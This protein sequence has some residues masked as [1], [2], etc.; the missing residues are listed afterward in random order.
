MLGKIHLFFGIAIVVLFAYTGHY[1]S[2]NFQYT[3]GK[4][5]MGRALTRAGHLYIL[6]FGLINAALGAHLKLSKNKLIR[7][8]QKFGSIIIFGSTLLVVYGFFT[9]LPASE[10]RRP[11]TQKS[12]Y[13]ILLGVTIHGLTALIPEKK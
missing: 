7:T 11:M 9:E 5:M 13:L 10:I 2:E 8:F 3:E 4:E 6:L 12:L 1:L